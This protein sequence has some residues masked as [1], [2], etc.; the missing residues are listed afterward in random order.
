MNLAIVGTR[1][2]NNYD[3][4]KSIILQNYNLND[5]NYIVSGGARG[6][7]SLAE[8]FALDFGIETKIFLPDWDKYGK[9]AGY[10]RNCL[11]IENADI[12]VAFW[13]GQSK[14]TKHSI[15]LAA[16]GKKELKI[17]RYDEIK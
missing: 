3:L 11:I 1:N 15:D 5:I 8:K 7:D 14:G 13:D 17:V 12:I 16:K 4:L 6:A 2:F 10:I 9:S